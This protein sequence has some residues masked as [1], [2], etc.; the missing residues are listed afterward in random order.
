MRKLNIIIVLCHLGIFCLQAME[1][2]RME[3]SFW[4]TGMKNSELQIMLYG[5]DIAKSKVQ[6]DYEGVRIK[7]IVQVENPN[8]L[9]VYLE[10]QDNAQPGIMQGTIPI[11]RPGNLLG[12]KVMIGIMREESL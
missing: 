9:F 7:E 6:L 12:N 2:S 4:W 8:Y 10:L 11:E 1:I 3:P 5:K